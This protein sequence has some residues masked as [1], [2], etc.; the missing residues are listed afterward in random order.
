M[1]RNAGVSLLMAGVGRKRKLLIALLDECEYQQYGTTN[2]IMKQYLYRI[3]GI[4]FFCV[5]SVG[6]FVPLLPTVPL[7]I[8]AA[9]FF[10]GSS[11]SLQQR[12]Y[13]HPHFGKTVSD[14]VEHGVMTRKGKSYAIA[15]SGAGTMISLVIIR[16][17]TSI[18]WFIVIVMLFVALWLARRPESIT[19]DIND[20]DKSTK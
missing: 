14:F 13:S 15:G 2:R 1:H 8:V 10:A 11:P 3:L 9:I 6:I 20:T 7:W 18:L 19:A 16:P 4:I 17:S 12:I 5:G